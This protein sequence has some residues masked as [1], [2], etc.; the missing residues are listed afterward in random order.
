MPLRAG[1]STVAIYQADPLNRGREIQRYLPSPIFV[2]GSFLCGVPCRGSHGSAHNR[3]ESETAAEQISQQPWPGG[4]SACAA[5]GVAGRRGVFVGGR[6]CRAGPGAASQAP[7]AAD[8]AGGLMCRA[9]S[10][11]VFRPPAS[12]AAPPAPTV[13]QSLRGRPLAWAQ[14][15][16]GPRRGFGTPAGSE[17]VILP[18]GALA[19]ARLCTNPHLSRG[20]AS[21][22][23]CAQVS[24]APRRHSAR[25]RWR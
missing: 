1:I 14:L 16:R 17:A 24:P 10:Q 8:S 2:M 6:R 20:P 4:G 19:S 12:G 7:R 3:V 11:V 25:N 21:C 22:G 23:A 18:P 13:A 9:G 15:R 5:T